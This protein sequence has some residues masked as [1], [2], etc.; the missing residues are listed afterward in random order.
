MEEPDYVVTEP[1][2]LDALHQ[3][4][5]KRTEFPP[6][7]E[8]DYYIPPYAR[9]LEGMKICLDPGHGGD[10]DRP[11]YKR[12][13]TDYREAVMNWKVA[14]FL[15]TFLEE[16]GAEVK[17]TRDG[18]VFVSLRD[19]ARVANDWGADIFL[20]IHHNAAGPTANRTTTW[21]HGHPDYE[22]ANLD[23]ARYIQVGVAEA[24]RLPQTDTVPLKSDYLMYPDAG[25]G[26]LRALRTVGCLCEASF[27]TNPYEEYRLQQDWYLKREAYGHFLGLARYAW[28]GIP[29]AQLLQPAGGIA[30]DKQPFIEIKADTGYTSRTNWGNDQPWVLSDSVTLRLDGETIPFHYDK[31]HTLITTQ[32]KEPLSAGDHVLVAGYR[33]HQGNYAH[34]VKMIL[35]VDPPVAELTLTLLP[36]EGPDAAD[37]PTTLTL[38]AFDKDG[39]P[40]R[41]GSE[42]RLV[43]GEVFFT[44]TTLHTQNGMA[45]THI[46][47]IEPDDPEKPVVIEVE[48]K[49]GS[50]ALAL[51][52]PYIAPLVWRK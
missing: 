28:M 1:K 20:S 33:N 43:S 22:P 14:N 6:L 19:R 46:T 10:A 17:L 45:S 27:F 47:K 12:G 31:A 35:T 29:R 26:V 41:D 2:A 3:A 42:F 23:V 16:A 11:R 38:K 13:P 52:K 9:L 4:W 50:A 32:L 44:T 8:L 30:E 21:F 39:Q 37:T 25:F 36:E 34:P 15:K 24:L 18:D 5:G 7:N 51:S 49:F 48:G 40:V